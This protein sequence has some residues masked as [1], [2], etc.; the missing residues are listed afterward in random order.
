MKIKKL[1]GKFAADREIKTYS[2]LINDI[3][4]PVR[5]A[6]SAKRQILRDKI[7]FVM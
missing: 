7:Y 4:K 1:A 3:E 5:S 6:K 2:L